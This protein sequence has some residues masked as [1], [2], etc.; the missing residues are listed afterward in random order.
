MM[1]GQHISGYK[2]IVRTDT[3]QPVS[4][5]KDTYKLVPN[6]ELIEDFLDGLEATGEDWK[7]DAY[8][9]FVE[10]TR[11]RLHIT[12]PQMRLSDEDSDMPLSLYLHNSYDYSE[13]VRSLWGF[14][15]LVCTNGMVAGHTL[16]K[17]VARHTSG[18]DG[19]RIGGDLKR[20]MDN[21]DSV[22]S[23]I[24]QMR[25]SA[26]LQPHFKPLVKHMGIKRVEN[27]LGEGFEQSALYESQWKLY[28][29]F[30]SWISHREPHRRQA[31]L[32]I[33][34]SKAFEL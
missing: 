5:V 8:H 1:A 28:N 29:K 20:V 11:M 12:F 33:G 14:I 16:G 22:R 10:D 32:Q 31:D 24:D 27:V 23:R 9:S 30:T 6:S 26:M 18:F 15:R 17:M 3:Q 2:A 21:L 34:L 4:I 25:N 13:S 19:A 7:I